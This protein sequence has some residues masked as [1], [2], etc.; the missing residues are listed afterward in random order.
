ME[1]VIRRV[2]RATKDFMCASNFAALGKKKGK[3]S[4][5]IRELFVLAVCVVVTSILRCENHCTMN[6]NGVKHVTTESA[7]PSFRLPRAF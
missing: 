6:N 3:R 1:R 7:K 5:R 4:W 2:T